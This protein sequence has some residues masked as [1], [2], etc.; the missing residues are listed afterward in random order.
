[1]APISE[2]KI[3]RLPIDDIEIGD[4]LRPV[5]EKGV[6]SLIASINELGVIKDAIHVRKARRKD[7]TR[8]ILM[9]GG[10]RLEAARRLGWDTIPARVWVDVT[11][12]FAALMEI[13]DN[14]AGADLSPLEL[15]VFLAKRKR[16]YERMH[17]ETRNGA[18]GGRGGKW[19]EMETVSF[20]KSIAEK[21]NLSD[22]HIRNFLTIGQSLTD[23]EIADLSARK[24]PIKLKDLMALAK[25][26]EPLV[27]SDVVGRIT[28]GGAASV[29]DA[30]AQLE[31]RNPP[32]QTSKDDAAYLKMSAYWGR[33]PKKSKRQ[34]VD[35]LRDELIDLL[36]TTPDSRTLG[37]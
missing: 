27:R 10:H 37:E 30:L 9:A 29:K 13:D 31:S 6:D 14:L 2:P 4:R 18:N 20:S 22:R 7:G 16:I 28:A 3:Q 32:P 11:D 25:I 21:R 24:E 15:S 36:E 5:S 26:K 17:P 19:N 12:D 33:A 35:T 34:F 1:M 23:R 8:L